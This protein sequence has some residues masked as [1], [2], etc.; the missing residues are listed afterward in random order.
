MYEASRSHVLILW[1]LGAGGSGESRVYEAFE[2]KPVD[3]PAVAVKS[4]E[5]RSKVILFI[6]ICIQ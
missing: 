6:Y 2:S 5:K 4:E 1:C 3:L